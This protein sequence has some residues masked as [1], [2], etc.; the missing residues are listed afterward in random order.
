MFHQ[1]NKMRIHHKH[2]KI[3][4]ALLLKMFNHK[5]IRILIMQKNSFKKKKIILSSIKMKKFKN[6]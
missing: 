1:I 6:S 4:Q 5:K 2:L 3:I